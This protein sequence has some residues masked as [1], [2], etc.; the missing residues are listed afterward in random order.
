[1]ILSHELIILTSFNVAFFNVVAPF[2]HRIFVSTGNQPR[3][4]LTDDVFLPFF[5]PVK[6][7]MKSSKI[8]NFPSIFKAHLVIHTSR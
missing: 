4:F 5:L 7:I 6:Q 2:K 1:M 8:L 3:L